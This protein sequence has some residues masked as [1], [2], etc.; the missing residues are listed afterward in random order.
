MTRNDLACGGCL[1][2]QETPC[3]TLFGFSNRLQL[4]EVAFF[5]HSVEFKFN[6]T[7]GNKK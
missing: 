6:T 4:S 5:R 3:G 1:S 7:S 2:E